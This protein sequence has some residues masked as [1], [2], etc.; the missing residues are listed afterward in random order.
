MLQ[1][2]T[3]FEEVADVTTFLLPKFPV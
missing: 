2:N 3:V 1:V